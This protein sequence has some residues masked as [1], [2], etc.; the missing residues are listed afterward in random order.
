MV[1]LELF[2]ERLIEARHVVDCLA[3]PPEA[4]A[5]VLEAVG[6]GAPARVRVALGGQ[7]LD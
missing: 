5:D 1:H 6:Q 2:D 3:R 7:V 4:P